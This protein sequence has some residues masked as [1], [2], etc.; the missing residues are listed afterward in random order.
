MR[1]RIT[2]VALLAVAS[3][4]DARDAKT[5]VTTANS[6]VIYAMGYL[7]EAGRRGEG[8]VIVRSPVRAVAV[9]VAAFVA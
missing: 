5:L 3:L 2:A 6:D 8:R 7:V 1:S 9:L 4:A